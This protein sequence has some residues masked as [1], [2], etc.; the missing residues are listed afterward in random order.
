MDNYSADPFL[1]EDPEI[2]L[3]QRKI[4][5]VPVM[6]GFT[7]DEGKFWTSRLDSDQ[8]FAEKFKKNWDTC[9]PINILGK[10]SSNITESD[11]DFIN[12]LVA[13][14]DN[15]GGTE[16]AEHLTNVFSDAV[17]SFST[18]KVSQY[19]VNSGNKLV[20]KYFFAYSGNYISYIYNSVS[21]ICLEEN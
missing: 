4:N 14:Y 5:N 11:V 15:D 10:E 12:S 18:H 2:L 13:N 1:P 19:L 21:Q 17:F 8:V 20:F 9:G 6:L 16:S 7:K 3:Q